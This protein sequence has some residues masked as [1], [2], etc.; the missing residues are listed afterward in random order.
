MF[1][2]NSFN[3]ANGYTKNASSENYKFIYSYFGIY[4]ALSENA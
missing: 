4:Q 1:A 3:T 2:V